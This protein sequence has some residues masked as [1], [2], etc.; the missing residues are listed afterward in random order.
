[1]PK[2]EPGGQCPSVTAETLSNLVLKFLEERSSRKQAWQASAAHITI[3]LTAIVVLGLLLHAYRQFAKFDA[4]LHALRMKRSMIR[5][6]PKY[7]MSVVR[8]G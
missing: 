8:T 4:M 6:L 2:T 1:M 5:S 3:A 7:Y